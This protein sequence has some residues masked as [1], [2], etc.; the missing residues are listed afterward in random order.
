MT[1]DTFIE[2]L[3]AEDDLAA[4]LRG[5]LYV[6]VGLTHDIQKRLSHPEALN[7]QRLRFPEKID[8]A[9]ALGAIRKE[10]KP[11]LIKLNSL[12][13][14]VAHNLQYNISV[15]DVRDIYNSFDPDMTALANGAAELYPKVGDGM[16]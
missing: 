10:D 4:L 12:R 1:L 3:E 9:I 8:L 2:H 15:Q 14:K 16:R 11:P 5:Y 7:V 6:E 13:N